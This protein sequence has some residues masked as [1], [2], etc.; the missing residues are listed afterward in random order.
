MLMSNIWRQLELGTETRSQSWDG[1]NCGRAILVR[2]RRGPAK[3]TEE[4]QE[5]LESTMQVARPAD[6]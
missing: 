4:S 5:G 6:G 1:E 3:D 2:I